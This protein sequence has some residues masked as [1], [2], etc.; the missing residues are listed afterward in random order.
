MT[1][2]SN[3]A[4][5]TQMSPGFAFVIKSHEYFLTSHKERI[6]SERLP[7]D[8]EHDP[9]NNVDEPE[10]ITRKAEQNRTFEICAYKRQ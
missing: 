5:C 9:L 1:L 7:N 4:N 10:R 3:G 2:P 8:G 6:R